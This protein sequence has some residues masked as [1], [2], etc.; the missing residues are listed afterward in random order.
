M[1]IAAAPADSWR[2]DEQSPQG[3]GAVHLDLEPQRPKLA[4]LIHQARIVLGAEVA[5]VDQRLPDG[6]LSL[7]ASDGAAPGTAAEIHRALVGLGSMGD[8]EALNLRRLA[9]LG[10]ESARALCEHGASAAISA[11]LTLEGSRVGTMYA[12]KRETGCFRDERLF[13]VFATQAGLALARR[14]C[15][16]VL[17]ALV[18][19]SRSLEALDLVALSA[20]TF[21]EL[22]AAIQDR[23]SSL[24]GAELT[25]LMVWDQQ[26][27]VLQLVGGSFGSS[28]EMAASYQV[29][30]SDR[31]S[32]AARVLATGHPYL[33]N[34][35]CRDPGILQDWVTAFHLKRLISVPL[36]LSDRAV[37]VLHLA[38]KPVDFTLEDVELAEIF[39][40]R[41]AVAVETAGTLFRLR[42][43]SQLEGVL[44]Q[45]AVAIAGG[46]NIQDFLLP[47]LDE[48]R[49]ATEASMLAIVPEG[50]EPLVSPR[51]TAHGPLE[52]IVL[53]EAA[54]MPGIR[55]YVVGP[56]KVGDPGWAVFHAPIQ[57]GRQRIGTLSAL[58][59]RGEPFTQDERDALMRLANLAALAGASER[60]QQHRAELARLQER[61]RIA[62]DL[63]DHV[64]QILF[65]VQLQLDA[66]L[67]DPA[68]DSHVAEAILRARGLLIRGDSAI[69]T[70]I[71]RLS[72]PV[73]ADLPQRLT[74]LVSGFETEFSLP[75]HLELSKEA[76]KASKSIGKPLA[77]VLIKVAREALANA[78]KHAGPC[79]V[80]VSLRINRRGR[81]MLTVVDDGLGL[82]NG[83]LARRHGLGSLRRSVL[84]HGGTLRLHR[85]PAGGMKVTAS[86]P[87]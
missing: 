43:R 78:A 35:A 13:S 63:H 21:G 64:A 10:S 9:D 70:V 69:R 60:Y 83:R 26:R 48:L 45:V 3:S 19:Q 65:G 46:K 62:D 61:Q 38:N 36:V 50:S 39:A 7:V 66:V 49:T 5:L 12:I 55:A 72:H 53:R 27:E 22:L 31:R 41:I 58:R 28:E 8:A 30:A 85:G 11:G 47:T 14:G 2:G 71:R 32:N 1:S 59:I 76:A 40:R 84:Q 82:P 81:L 77:D 86:V 68:V 74:T 54:S 23:V 67:E 56:L 24:I 4:T 51:R 15:E 29:R 33:S 42:G 25:G 75:T 79:R 6:S 87:L 16:H 57:L 37:G 44:A 73:H 52:Q 80:D 18:E 20:S 17:P 34:E